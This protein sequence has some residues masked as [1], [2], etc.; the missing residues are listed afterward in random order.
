[1][2]IST[3]FLLTMENSFLQKTLL[4]TSPLAHL[5][6]YNSKPNNEI[7]ESGDNLTFR[8]FLS[9]ALVIDSENA[10][11]DN[12]IYIHEPEVKVGRVQNLWQL[13]TILV[14]DGKTCL[15]LEY[16]VNIGDELWTMKDEDLISLAKDELEKLSLI[17]KDSVLEGYV[18]RMPKAYPVYDLNYSDNI[19]NIS[20]WLNKEHTNIFPVGKMECIDIIIKIIQ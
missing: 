8:D 11:P 3:K 19:K 5:K 17:T 13:V 15:G 9:V 12:W 16:F 7:I 6:N 2:K 10:F 1:M 18:V 20:T 4:P 14:K